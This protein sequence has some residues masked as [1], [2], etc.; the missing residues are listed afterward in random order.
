[1]VEVFKSPVN[2]QKTADMAVVRM[3]AVS[4]PITIEANSSVRATI[5]YGKA[6]ADVPMVFYSIVCADNVFELSH[7]IYEMRNDGFI[8]CIENQSVTPR[9]VK[10]VYEAKN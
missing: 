1:M 2:L 9:T 6:L 10:V 4:A 5:P 7:Y 3:S 8:I